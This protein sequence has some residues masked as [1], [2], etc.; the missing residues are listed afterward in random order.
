MPEHGGTSN[1]RW[2]WSWRH[3]PKLYHKQRRQRHL[4]LF[5]RLLRAATSWWRER[6]R[7][8]QGLL[9]P[10]MTR[11]GPA[12]AWRL[13]LKITTTRCVF[14][15]IASFRCDKVIDANSSQADGPLSPNDVGIVIGN[16]RAQ[17]L[18][19]LLQL[20]QG[21][22]APYAS[23]M[24]RRVGPAV[25][26]ARPLAV[27][28]LVRAAPGVESYAE[29]QRDALGADDLGVVVAAAAD[30]STSTVTVRR[31]R[32]SGS[33]WWYSLAAVEAAA[34]LS[35]SAVLA[36]SDDGQPSL[37]L[38]QLACLADAED[39]PEDAKDSDL[40]DAM[41]ETNSRLRGAEIGVLTRVRHGVVDVRR[42]GS[43]YSC[44]YRRQDLVPATGTALAEAQQPW[45]PGDRVVR[46][47]GYRGPLPS[48]TRGPRLKWKH[49]GVVEAVVGSDA[50][51][52]VRVTAPCGS[53]LSYRPEALERAPAART[54]R[55]APD[56]NA[57]AAQAVTL[58]A[59][60]H[61]HPLGARAATWPLMARYKASCDLCGN[62]APAA[63]SARCTLGCE[64]DL[65]AECLGRE[66][67]QEASGREHV[68]AAELIAAHVAANRAAPGT[69]LGAAVSAPFLALHE[70][71]LAG[72]ADAALWP[73][74]LTW[75]DIRWSWSCDVCHERFNGPDDRH[76][77][78]AGCDWDCCTECATSALLGLTAPSLKQGDTVVLAQ[79][80]ARYGDAA[81]GHLQPGMVGVV[82]AVEP[83]DMLSVQVQPVDDAEAS[84]WY[85]RAALVAMPAA[86]PP[87]TRGAALSSAPSANSRSG[88]S[89]RGNA[90][91][92]FAQAALRDE[93]GSDLEHEQLPAA[94]VAAL[95]RRVVACALYG[96]TPLEE[97]QEAEGMRLA[98][99]DADEEVDGDEGND[100]EDE[101]EGLSE[102]LS[103]EIAR[104][105]VVASSMDALGAPG[106]DA[107]LRP[108]RV[109]F[110]ATRGGQQEEGI[111][112]SGLSREWYTVTA[113]ALMRI[114]AIMPTG[115]NNGEFYFN[116]AACSAQD[117][118]QCEFLGAF[119]GRALVEGA[120]PGRVARLGHVTLGDIRL[121][122][123]FYKV[124]LGVPL[125][126]ADLPDVSA[127][128]ARAL[129]MLLDEPRPEDLCLGTFVHEVFV[130]GADGD[131]A[132]CAVLPLRP[133]GASIPITRHNKHEYVMLKT[134]CLLMTSV[135]R[136]LDA[137]CA[138]FF[139]L[140]PPAVLRG[141]GISPRALRKLLCG[142][143]PGFDVKELR[144]HTQYAAPYS[145]AHPVIVWLWEVLR[146]GTP[147]FQSDFL[148]FTTGCPTPPADGFA[149]LAAALPAGRYPLTV[150][151]VPLRSNGAT[152]GAPRWPQAHT[153]SCTLDLPPYES[154]RM[155]CECLERALE[156]K[157]TYAFS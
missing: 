151:Q 14:F 69:G 50:S 79:D 59:G 115:N 100:D 37:R 124:L 54:R 16:S 8:H 141:S 15:A 85:M 126:L 7:L 65:C 155:L 26:G 66:L 44:R 118:A 97:D 12:C 128:D 88:F 23:A 94:R 22:G 139:K 108:L 137:A 82:T 35:R 149:A 121:C 5:R 130:P 45:A 3:T 103:V 24:L 53:T 83:E 144:A 46:R 55:T 64:F 104:D 87:P 58:R 112:G 81:N 145:T 107:W 61:G 106:E 52:R 25:M 102:S 34:T 123:A 62:M 74:M 32:K 75:R 51:T 92:F 9:F 30:G 125:T 129:Q 98:A 148:E 63:S 93:A 154:K 101:D 153:C 18:V 76:R 132:P 29:L 48:A 33:E 122:D 140:S 147:Q 36:H 49:I 43:E 41:E 119:L 6:N 17:V 42:L 13:D 105:S 89:P 131:A 10:V 109:S 116:P 84:W 157:N 136:Q 133:G 4:R 21:A 20:V 90:W 31:L 28:D 40:E 39:E 47:Y 142:G 96:V 152:T 27:G 99:T 86:A 19:E 70:H 73:R 60:V 150:Q 2:N 91:N 78:T 38:G 135:A 127:S 143:G 56:A 77:C 117:L 68:T 114:P 1:L 67:G 146:E 138:G 57:P 71:P 156:H 80:F 120:A 110:V 113:R 95:R 111:D 134:Q 11:W 72:L